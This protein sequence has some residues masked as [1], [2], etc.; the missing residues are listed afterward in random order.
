MWF[1]SALY[2]PTFESTQTLHLLDVELVSKYKSE[3]RS[4]RCQGTEVGCQ[5]TGA[6]GQLLAGRCQQKEVGSRKWKAGKGRSTKISTQ[7]RLSSV[8]CLLS[9]LLVLMLTTSCNPDRPNFE[10][11]YSGAPPGE[12]LDQYMDTEAVLAELEQIKNDRKQL[13]SL[14]TL[15]DKMKNND[16][17][18][19]LLYA[20]AAYIL[21]TGKDWRLST[22]IAAYY[23]ALLKG[24]SG[25]YGEGLADA[26]V[27]A[28]H[29]KPIFEELHATE[30]IIRVN[31]LIGI[32]YNQLGKQDSVKHYLF[33]AL[34]VLNEGEANNQDYSIL[35]GE[36]FHDLANYYEDVDS[37]ILAEDYF[38]NSHQYYLSTNN[39]LALIPL[40]FDWAQFQY[41]QEEFQ[42]AEQLINSGLQDALK[43]N[44]LR[45]VF[46]GYQRFGEL[47]YYRFRSTGQIEY[48]EKT[49]ENYEKCFQYQKEDLYVLHNQIGQSYQR[50]ASVIDD[51]QMV[52]ACVDS[53]LV[54]Y[55][56]AMEEARKEG[57]LA[58][59]KKMGTNISRLCSWRSQRFNK[60]C[61]DLLGSSSSEFLSL[62]YTGITDT[63]ANFLFSAKNENRSLERRELELK[64]QE[65]LKVQ[66]LFSTISLLTFGLIFVVLLF[67][68]QQRRLNARMEVLRAQINPHFISNSL[69]AIEGF[70]NLDQKQKAVKYLIHFSRLMRRVIHGAKDG[71]VSLAGEVQTL[72]HFLELEQLRFQDKLL[73]LIDIDEDIQ[74][75]RIEIPAMILQPYI[76][77]AI[78]QGIKPKKGKGIVKVTVE[79]DGKHLICTIKDDGIGRVKATEIKASSV[80]KENSV[81]IEIHQKRLFGRTRGVKVEIVDLYE[82][83]K[84]TGTKVIIRL[85]FKEIRSTKAEYISR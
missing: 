65:K 32:F 80:L 43:L 3:K 39:V 37:F 41:R 70:I 78:W 35:K 46:L 10:P 28:N 52:F 36:L 21:A 6:N 26:L 64:G 68:Q 9:C 75:K 55:R 69:N 24:R 22:G 51:K 30:W 74:P 40:K 85:P 31:N 1:H 17:E 66:Q 4:L 73:Y 33:K 79:K 16:V 34:D 19:A 82:E 81:G 67:I 14:L 7:P 84:A 29:S 13:D 83:G 63:I 48:F 25:V 60:D 61:S 44:H 45:G 2:S 56:R 72:E 15:A 77:N 62:N 49:L 5:M 50:A 20:E 54:S 59:L 23:M 53:A 38:Q 71:L 12:D 8:F 57:A 47:N 18:S 11:S 27:D 76:E 58:V 42:K